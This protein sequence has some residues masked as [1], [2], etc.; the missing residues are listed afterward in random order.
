MGSA[1]NSAPDHPP[2]ADHAPLATPPSPLATQ[3]PHAIGYEL[4]QFIRLAGAQYHM[5]A[6]E[7]AYHNRK[8]VRPRS[9]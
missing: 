3:M 5:S 8:H 9:T 2:T 6:D 4:Q 7:I 1:A